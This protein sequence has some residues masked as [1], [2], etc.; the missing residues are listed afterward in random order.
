M[1]IGKE[2]LKNSRNVSPIDGKKGAGNAKA[3]PGSPRL[4]RYKNQKGYR[5]KAFFM[6]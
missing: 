5:M 2:K 1:P 3:V 6:R 4:L